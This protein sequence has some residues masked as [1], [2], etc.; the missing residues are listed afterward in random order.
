[1]TYLARAILEA[2]PNAD[3]TLNGDTVDGLEWHDDSITKP[4]DEELT[5]K[6]TELENGEPLARLRS[7]R[8]I[9]LAETDW[10]VLSDTA[11]MTSDQTIYRQALRDITKSYNSL[12]NVVWPT[13]P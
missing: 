13:K 9:K 8:D 6:A 5:A 4:S 12:D 10:W 3:F 11:E 2:A 1:M 7:V